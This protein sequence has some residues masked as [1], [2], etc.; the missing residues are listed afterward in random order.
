MAWKFLNLARSVGDT[1][2]GRIME[3]IV[4]EWRDSTQNAHLKR[5]AAEALERVAPPPKLLFV[6]QVPVR[7]GSL[8]ELNFRPSQAQVDAIANLPHKP[9]KE[10][11]ERIRTE[12]K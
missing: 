3:D 7:D 6:H 12:V 11:I 4:S 2:V 8:V 10:E 5:W 1:K 9:T